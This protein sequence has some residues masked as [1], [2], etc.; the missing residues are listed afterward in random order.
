[1]KV[2]TKKII[3]RCEK[4]LYEFLRDF[5]RMHG[6]TMSE[7][8][9]DVL[10]YY[11]MGL[12]IGDFSKSYAELKSDFLKSKRKYKPKEFFRLMKKKKS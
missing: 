9:R 8:I 1:M 10:K 7:L 2:K 11:H 4:N 12:L 5:A 6:Q 3:F